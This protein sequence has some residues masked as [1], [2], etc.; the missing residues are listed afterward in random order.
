[1]RIFS[2]TPKDYF[3]SNMYV[4]ESSGI[5]VIIDPSVNYSCVSEKIFSENI[6]V[7]YI[8]I[9]HAHFDHFLE[10]HSWVKE[11]GAKVLIG[12]A[13]APALA[14]S[15]LN[16]YWQFMGLDYGYSGEYTVIKDSECI[17]FGDAELQIIE[18]PGH[19]KGSVSFF[20]EGALFVGD[21]L[22]AGGGFG[23][24]DLPGGDYKVLMQSIKKLL[25]FPKETKVYCGHGE[26]TSIFQLKTNF[27]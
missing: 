3:G 17:K 20:G 8:L 18:T 6:N 21:V 1:M 14:D 5:G 16:C 2:F 27:I 23:R 22:F 25:T 26:E 10:I 19:S 13:D 24:V 15:K 9:T 4:L 7:K 12:E 11:T